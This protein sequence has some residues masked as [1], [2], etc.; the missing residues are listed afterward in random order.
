MRKAARRGS[1]SDA[2]TWGGSTGVVC[3]IA[4]GKC[5]CRKSTDVSNHQSSTIRKCCAE[6]ADGW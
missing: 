3:V 6:S 4:V 2:R 5:I 1:M